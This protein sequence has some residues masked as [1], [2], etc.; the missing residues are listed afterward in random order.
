M[1]GVVS[2]TMGNS[3]VLL[4]SEAD[5]YIRNGVCGTVYNGDLHGILLRTAGGKAQ[6][7]QQR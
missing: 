7:K 5:A 2:L 3:P 4:R 6:T 1:F